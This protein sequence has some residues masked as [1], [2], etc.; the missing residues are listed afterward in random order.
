M[1][2]LFPDDQ[3]SSIKELSFAAVA[4]FSPFTLRSREKFSAGALEHPVETQ[5]QDEFY[6]ACYT[7]L[8]SLYLAS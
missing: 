8:N 4:E 7:V 2:P 5:Y 3:F 1:T 6:Q